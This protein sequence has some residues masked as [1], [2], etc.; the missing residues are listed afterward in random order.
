[1]GLLLFSG[2]DSGARAV[3]GSE[4][5]RSG[6]LAARLAAH[7]AAHFAAKPASTGSVTPV[8]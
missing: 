3:C 4:L 7:V 6:H 8:T 2:A 1:M 5:R